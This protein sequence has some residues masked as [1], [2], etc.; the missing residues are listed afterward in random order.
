MRKNE[1][2]RRAMKPMAKNRATMVS[3]FI[4]LAY[5]SVAI[6]DSIHFRVQSKNQTGEIE[7]LLDLALHKAKYEQEKT[8]SSPLAIFSLSKENTSTAD[9]KTIRSYPRLKY[10]GRHLASPQEKN[11]DLLTRL[12]LGF[13]WFIFF[14]LLF[15][16]LL[17]FY[18]SQKKNNYNLKKNIRYLYQELSWLLIS[19]SVLIFLFSLFYQFYGKYHILGTDK[20]GF[21]IFYTSMKSIRTGILIGTLT[22]LVVTP[23]AIVMGIASGY[24]RGWVDDL[25]QYIYTTFE[26]IPDILL[27]AAAML[28]A[29][30]FASSE[31]SL[32]HADRKF[33]YL[34]FILG[35]TS[36]TNLCR[37]IR[38][39][40]LK[41]RE[42]EFVEAARSFGV[43]QFKIMLNHILP[44][45][46]HIVFIVLV[47]RFSNLV[48]AE[49]VL[50]YVGI[51]VD[52]AIH[53]WGNMI[54]QARFELARE[55][56]VWWSLL[57]A[58]LFML[59]L[60]L[61]ANILADSARDA[62]D[63]KLKN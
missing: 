21:D 32:E 44:N 18:I 60:V 43:S 61:P 58:F 19:V 35:I 24:L 34:C 23:I 22:T 6:L 27:I 59:A 53:S 47:L 48:L 54:N 14:M 51:G 36:W 56:L 31:S 12:F 10:A 42:L 39:E 4:L 41:V 20:A 50:S 1:F 17:V 3:L 26:S 8:Y 5:L 15:L 30:T 16:G 11:I 52:S 28:I 9:G 62:L 45:I 57:S 2:W 33:L 13:A 49:A 40:T 55:P 29:E 46:I 7:S 63:P 38:A 37:L 25:I